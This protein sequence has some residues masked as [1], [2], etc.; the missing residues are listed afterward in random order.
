MEIYKPK[1][2]DRTEKIERGLEPRAEE[3]KDKIVFARINV[4][5]NHNYPAKYDVMS[6]PTVV[7]IK[8]GKEIG[9]QIGFAGRG[10][11]DEL[12]KKLT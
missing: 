6:I 2:S 9:R 10:G 12:I 11:Y 3:H 8:D 1:S 7:L 5:E 4:D